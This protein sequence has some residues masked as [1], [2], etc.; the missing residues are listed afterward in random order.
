MPRIKTRV[1]TCHGYFENS[2]PFCSI[3]PARS[4]YF[5]YFYRYSSQ[6]RFFFGILAYCSTNLTL[7][8][9]SLHW[10]P[11]SV[12][13]IVS[14]TAPCESQ[15]EKSNVVQHFCLLFEHR[16]K[17]H[18]YTHA[19]FVLVRHKTSHLTFT[20]HARSKTYTLFQYCTLK[21]GKSTPEQFH[22]GLPKKQ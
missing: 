10:H 22:S 16:S 1:N 13:A 14:S 19:L 4:Q 15:V 8:A 12:Q 6:L 5:C 2:R 7:A 17:P 11:C 18:M 20:P 9:P 21:P 3:S